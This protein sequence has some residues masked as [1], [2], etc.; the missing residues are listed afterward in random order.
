MLISNINRERSFYCLNKIYDTLKES[1]HNLGLKRFITPNPLTQSGLA[2]LQASNFYKAEDVFSIAFK[3][4]LEKIDK[5]DFKSLIKIP[6]IA[7]ALDNAIE[8]G[9]L[10]ALANTNFNNNKNNGNYSNISFAE[11]KELFSKKGSLNSNFESLNINDLITSLSTEELPDQIDLSI[12]E[13]GLIDCYRNT[14]NWNNLLQ[15]SEATNNIE[16]KIESFWHLEKWKEIE[17]L[18][19]NK[20]YYLSKLNQ[21]YTIMKSENARNDNSYQSKCMECIRTIF[22]DFTTFPANFEKLNYHYFLILQL[23]VEA[24]ESTNTLRE[25]EKNILESK[26]PD[27][28]EN[29]I[30]WRDR[31]PHISEGFHS[32]KSLLDPRNYLFKILR[33]MLQNYSQNRKFNYNLFIFYSIIINSKNIFFFLI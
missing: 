22:H 10:T 28:R 6:N 7:N 9:N 1:E 32:L 20:L 29:L 30:M 26:I 33:D 14:N 5:I 8:E 27:F 21:I 23:I 17:E 24:W 16:T 3:A 2:Y 31:I 13:S 18:N 11:A 25:I 12:W 15:L 4:Q 19:I